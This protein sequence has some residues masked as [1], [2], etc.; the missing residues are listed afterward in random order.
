LAATLTMT[1]AALLAWILINHGH[2]L[3]WDSSLHVAARDH[4]TSALTAVG[5]FLSG[6]AEA[7]AYGAAVTSGLLGQRRHRRDQHRQDY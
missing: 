7:L 2:P 1:F 4:R 6:S 5:A 3:S